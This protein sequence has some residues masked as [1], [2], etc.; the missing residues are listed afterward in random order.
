MNVQT[1]KLINQARD[2]LATAHVAEEGDH[3]GGSI[4]LRQIP[5]TVRALFEEFEG[6]VNGQMLS[7]LDEIQARIGA[8]RVRVVFPDGCEVPIQ[9]LQVYP[10]TQEV[11]FK[12]APVPDLGPELASPR[13]S[14]RE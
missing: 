3:Y 9:D 14:A 7:F 5:A 4:D 2:L 10:S 13:T 1:V 8:L 6:I 11:S 12:L